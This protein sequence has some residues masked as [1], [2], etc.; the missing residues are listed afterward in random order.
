MGRGCIDQIFVLKQQLAEKYIEKRKELYVGIIDLEKAY[1]NVCRGA[2]WKMLHE[3]GVDGYL[4]KSMS[5]LY[6][7]T[8]AFA[9]VGG[10]VRNILR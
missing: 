6:K 9:R 8:R 2:L 4:I 10:R 7:I 1:D 5:S 3:C